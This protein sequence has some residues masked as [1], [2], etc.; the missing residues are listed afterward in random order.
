MTAQ[1]RPVSLECHV[2]P[3]LLGASQIASYMGAVAGSVIDEAELAAATDRLLAGLAAAGYPLAAVDSAIFADSV[4]HRLA[5]IY[6][7]LGPP[8]QAT[9]EDG[10]GGRRSSESTLTASRLERKAT[11]LLD[12]LTDA[13][14]PFATVSFRLKG[15]RLAGDDLGGAVATAVATGP[16]VRI[17]ELRFPGPERSAVTSAEPPRSA[18]KDHTVDRGRSAAESAYQTYLARESRL[19]RGDPFRRQGIERAQRRLERLPMVTALGEPRLLPSS[20]GIVDIEIPLT[21]RGATRLTGV[22]SLAPN[23]GRPTGEVQVEVG[24]LFGGGRRLEFGWFGLNPARRGVRARY[25]EGWVGGLP[26]ELSGELEGWRVEGSHGSTT[27]RLGELWEPL[28]G[29][30]LGLAGAAQRI[31]KATDERAGAAVVGSRT[32]WLETSVSLDRFDDDWNPAAGYRL[33][34]ESR[35]GWRRSDESGLGQTRLRRD[36][37]RIEMAQRLPTSWVAYARIEH[38]QIVGEGITPEEL[39]R[40]GGV[41]TVRGYAEDRYAALRALIGA[42]ELRFRPDRRWGYVGLTADAGWISNPDDAPTNTLTLL[43]CGLTAAMETA[44]GRLGLELAWP[45]VEPLADTRLHFR[46]TGW[47]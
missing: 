33:V 21:T 42:A 4:G 20:P 16:F 23:S 28:D 24:N 36:A 17:G 6:V 15:A 22:A 30:R 38:H 34:I 14:F 26:V 37:T 3:A 45:V 7:A 41:G 2:S 43:S 9:M 39:V 5:D 44:A 1:A 27:Y 46:L 8:L 12:S 32:S 35:H 11:A 29:V 40:V 31:S 13:G 25:T 18:A 10:A 19:N 47:L